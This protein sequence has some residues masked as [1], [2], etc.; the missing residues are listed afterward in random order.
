MRLLGQVAVYVTGQAVLREPTL[1]EKLRRGLGSKLD[2]AT[3]RVRVELEATAVVDHVRRALGRLGVTNALSLV[4]DDTVLF[5]DT[6]GKPDDLP[7]L[8]LA[9]AEHADVFGRGFRELRF[10]A[11]H[12]EAGLHLVIEARARTE[13][14]VDEPAAV[15]S[16]GGRLQAL[17]PRSGESADDYRR[18]VEPLTKDQAA[19]ETARLQF[20]SFVARLEEALRAGMPE[21]RIEELKSEARLVRAAPTAPTAPAAEASRAPSHPAYDPYATYYP[22]PMGLMLDAMILTS[23]MHALAPSPSILVMSPGGAPI[24]SV[25]EVAAEPQ[26]LEAAD[27]QAGDPTHYDGDDHGD[28]P[29][30]GDGDDNHDADADA[31]DHDAGDFGDDLI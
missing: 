10:A 26:R 8:V 20:Q 25:A 7:D 27:H 13:H 17:E 12:R 19:F 2:L 29:G 14:Q 1:W 15:V 3:D 16:V 23:L 31:F 4:V 6:D 18:R 21:A 30:I 11:E 24:G 9:L 22:N 5:Q 28:E